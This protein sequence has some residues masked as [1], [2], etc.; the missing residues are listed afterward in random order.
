MVTATRG[1]SRDSDTICAASEKIKAEMDIELCASL[2]IL[3]QAKA[4]RLVAAWVDRFNHNLERY[5]NQMVSTHTWQDRV[6][7]VQIAKQAGM[8]NSPAGGIVGLGENED[9]LLDR[10]AFALRDLDVD[11]VPVNFLDARPGT[12]LEVGRWLKPVTHCA[13]MFRFVHPRT[14]LRVAGGR[15]LTLCSMQAMALNQRLRSRRVTSP[16]AVRR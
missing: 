16:P 12:P 9:D 1:P 11:S 7:T 15:E 6:A 13:C 8:D 2:G 14:D 10:Q 3:N 4:E 5:Y